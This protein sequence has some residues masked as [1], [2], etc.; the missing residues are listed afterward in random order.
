MSATSSS[1]TRGSGPQRRGLLRRVRRQVHP[2]GA[3]RRRG[4]GRRR[5]REGQGRPRLRR[6]AERPAGQLHRP[7][8][9]R[10]PR[11]RGSPSTRAAP[12]SSSSART[13]TTPARTRS[14]TCWARPCSPSGWARP[15]SSPRPARAS[16]ASPPPPPAPS[17]AS[18]APSTWARSTPQRQA[19]NVARMRMLGAEVVAV[20]S[21]SRTLKDAINEAFRDWVA[22]VDRTHYLFGTV[23]GPHPF[24]RDGA[25]LPP[26]HRRRGPPPDPGA[27][28][29]AAG[30]GRRLRRRRLQRHRPLPRVPPGRGRPPRRPARPPATASSP[31]STPPR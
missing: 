15:A 11:C 10:S 26:R 14:T 2:G 7:A 6:R 23:A 4:R 17:S 16:T 24:P 3:G 22:N 28:R 25:R 30:R 20:T 1:P 29:P 31:A 5:V 12:G 21:G 27:G 13:S 8:Q 19:L 9:R 18:S